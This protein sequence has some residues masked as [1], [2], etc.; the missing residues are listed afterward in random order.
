[1]TAPVAT[2]D[3]AGFATADDGTRLYWRASGPSEGPSRGTI[4]CC[5]GVGVSLFFWKYL[6]AH[7]AADHEVLLWDYRAHGRSDR[8]RHL[9]GLDMGIPR[10]AED[11]RA[12]MDAAGVSEAMLVGHSMGCQVVFEFHRR[13]PSRVRAMVPML[14]TAGRLLDTFY[15]N[16]NSPA[17]FR[18]IAR[19]VDRIGERTHRITRP[20]LESPLAW[21]FAR[22][23]SLVDP[24][25]TREE[26]MVPYMRHL[27]TLDMRVFLRTVLA[28][29]DHDAWDTLPG[30]RVPVL[31]IAAERD[32]F[33]PVSVSRDM[34]ARIPG[35]E[36]LVLAD[37][38]HAA[39]IEQ[40][41][42]ILHRVDRFLRERSV[43]VA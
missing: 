16:P 14:G 10:F 28:A 1:M 20:V 18:A 5:N 35:A 43:F 33:T 27:A 24:F 11:L 36:L 3:R 12:V 25:Y 37:G 23:A 31:I 26:D 40:P 29:G 41:E 30:A 7:Y 6:V 17:Y 9:T 8:P 13:Y 4:V 2:R 39:L 22:T 34:A 21:W 38:S 19:A 42:T 32:T 15:G